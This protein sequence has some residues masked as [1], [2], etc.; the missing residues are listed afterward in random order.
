MTA[1]TVASEF[2]DTCLAAFGIPASVITDNGGQFASVHYQGIFE[3]LGTVSRD[4]SPYHP[5][6]NRQ[7]ERYSRTLVRKLLCFVPE[8]QTDWDSHFPL[9]TTAY[10]PQLHVSAG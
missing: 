3:L 6:T 8:H 7:V 4:T 5:Q 10:S 1:L 2:I 9:L